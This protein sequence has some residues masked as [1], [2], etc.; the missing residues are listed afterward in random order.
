[1]RFATL[2]AALL[3]AVVC[4]QAQQPLGEQASAW[5][6]KAK[7]Y[8]PSM[9]RLPLEAGAAAVARHQLVELTT[10][11]WESVLAP[12]LHPRTQ[13]YG[14]DTWMVLVTGGNNTCGGRCGKIE[15]EFNKT[16][17]QFSTDKNGPRF[18]LLNCDKYNVLCKTWF[19][20]PP[21]L[22]YIQRPETMIGA[23]DEKTPIHVLHLNTTHTTAK[24][25]V[26]IHKE[27]KYERVA[28]MDSVFHPFDGQLQKYGIQ[29]P[30][31]YVLFLFSMIPSWGLMVGVSFMT[32]QFM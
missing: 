21:T 13:T 32:R 25:L 6:A 23:S 26:A 27:K 5:F 10:T 4:A 24:E 16:V 3:P 31:G 22:W 8:L 29:K 12:S 1:M 19:A 30:L 14:P 7:S 9:E 15:A 28:E 18:G 11:N 20:G 17:A 2:T